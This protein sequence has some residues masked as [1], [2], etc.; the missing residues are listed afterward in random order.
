ERVLLDALRATAAQ[1]QRARQVTEQLERARAILAQRSREGVASERAYANTLGTSAAKIAAI[2]A[3]ALGINSA[4]GLAR[5]GLTDL[6]DTAA[7]FQAL[8]VQ[9]GAVFQEQADEAQAAILDLA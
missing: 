2:G 5:R 1:E 7:R 8:D 4:L 9:L 3:A 6:L